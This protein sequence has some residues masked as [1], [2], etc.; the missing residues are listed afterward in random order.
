MTRKHFEVLISI[1]ESF[2]HSYPVCSPNRRQG[3]HDFFL[4]IIK[5]LF[6]RKVC[7][8]WCLSIYFSLYE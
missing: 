5:S 7:L 8:H 2:K 6:T 1:F 4:V 3:L